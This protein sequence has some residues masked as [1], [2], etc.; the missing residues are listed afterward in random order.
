VEDWDAQTG[1]LIS[2]DQHRLTDHFLRAPGIDGYL[3]VININ[4]IPAPVSPAEIEAIVTR[5]ESGLTATE[6]K[7]AGSGRYPLP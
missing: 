6:N 7:K 1:R 2:S 3:L 5:Y 4:D